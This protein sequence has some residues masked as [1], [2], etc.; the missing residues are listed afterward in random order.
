MD[1]EFK[2]SELFSSIQGEG[3][4]T[5][6]PTMWLRFFNCN[7][8]CPGFGQKD[9]DDPDSWVLPWETED[10]SKYTSLDQIPIFK[11]GCDS[12]YSWS[13]K[14]RHLIEKDT[15]DDIADKL[16][17][18]MINQHNPKG[19]FQHEK[20]KQETHLAFTGGEPMMNQVGMAEVLKSLS[21]KENPPRFITVETNGTR[22]IKDELKETIWKYYVTSE[23]DGLV[24]DDR[25]ST[26]WFWS[27]SPKLRSSGEPWNKTIC[28]EILAE[29]SEHSDNG[30]LKF[31]V[32]GSDRTWY[33]VD[34][35]VAA[36]REAEIYWPVWIM[37]E[38]ATRESQ[39]GDRIAKI[40]DDAIARGFNV[41]ARVH[42]Y[43]YGN[44]IGK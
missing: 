36:F 25:G 44:L 3:Q 7:L 39:E 41:S 30:Q 11:T 27:V 9:L 35:A 13:R 20:S 32:D 38:G 2:Y 43:I 15:A 21:K 10:F 12:G 6:I 40:A 24:P 34:K 42:C 5:G 16:I 31:V 8:T 23:I 17:Q 22:P 33:E 37:P 1:K 18:L 28:P 14:I 4:F 26:L 19:L 29:Y